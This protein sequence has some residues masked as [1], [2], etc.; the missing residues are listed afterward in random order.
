MGSDLVGVADVALDPAG[1]GTGNS[2]YQ[3][4]VVLET[5]YAIAANQSRTL[6]LRVTVLAF[7][8]GESLTTA[9]DQDLGGPACGALTGSCTKLGI[10]GTVQ[11]I[12]WSHDLATW[13]NGDSIDWNPAGAQTLTRD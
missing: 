1:C 5:P 11:N 8:S 10:G 7:Q 12:V 3:I 9:V 13:H 2:L 6:D 4:R